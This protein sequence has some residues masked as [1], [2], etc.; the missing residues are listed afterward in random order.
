MSFGSR[1]SKENAVFW[2]H[3]RGWK[4]LELFKEK[5]PDSIP[6]STIYQTGIP[7]VTD[8]T[9]SPSPFVKWR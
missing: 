9:A 3:R 8:L 2:Q 7:E 5:D 1:A 6:A 4:E